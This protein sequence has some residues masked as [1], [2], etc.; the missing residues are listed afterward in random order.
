M[1]RF[2]IFATLVLGTNALTAKDAVGVEE[3]K[4]SHD[5]AKHA[6]E[7]TVEAVQ[8]AVEAVQTE[9]V[10]TVSLASDMLANNEVLMAT[11]QYYSNAAFDSKPAHKH[12]QE[13]TAEASGIQPSTESSA[14]FLMKAGCMLLMCFAAIYVYSQNSEAVEAK[15]GM[16]LAHI[17]CV[18]YASLS[19]GIDLSIKNAAVAYGGHFPF[20]P[21]CGVIVVEFSKCV[22]SAV[23]LA[24][25]V[26]RDR[27]EGRDFVWPKLS[28]VAWLAV[29]AAIYAMNNM[30]VFQAIKSC[31][32][33][34]FGVI[35]ETMLV[36]NALIWCAT[37]QQS[38]SATRWLAIAGIFF[39]CS[40]NQIPKMLG[41]EW[42]MGVLWAFLLA[43]CNAAGAVANEYAMKQRAAL[44]INL[45]NCILYTLCG[46]FVFVGLAF[47]DPV[48]VSS[49]AEFFTGFVPECWQ[50]IILQVFTGLAVSR[51]LKYV[52]AVT[53]TIVAAIRGPGVIFF[54]AMI[55][56]TSLGL[57]EVIATLMV[58]VSCYV[59]LRQGPLIKPPVQPKAEATESTPLAAKLS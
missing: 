22:V 19:I 53:K 7:A 54:G 4:P 17:C 5:K 13:E 1:A 43:F 34:S 42:N 48:H 31:P 8:P 41:D 47:S 27:Q 58:C 38:I 35:R 45:Q 51:I 59:Y 21:A 24:F 46:S 25:V 36:W 12:A 33:S 52:E 50:I 20:H 6:K 2:I 32:L 9:V 37:F 11:R 40:V 16:K 10:Q 29:P 57:S 23:L 56:H 3:V 28:D 39:G 30:I 55:F 18:V 26:H 44:D 14:R 49:T 15:T